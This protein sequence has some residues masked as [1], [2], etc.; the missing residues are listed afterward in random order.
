[1]WKSIVQDINSAI[2]RPFEPTEFLSRSVP[3]GKSINGGCINQA[4]LLSDGQQQYFVKLNRPEMAGMFAAEAAGLSEI[5]T[6]QTITVPT[7]ICAGVTDQHAYLALSYLDLAG[8]S[9]QAWEKLGAELAAL[10][11][12]DPGKRFGWYRNNTIG[13]TPQINDWQDN[14]VE[15]FAN[16]RL[17]YQFQ[18]AT[19]RGGRFASQQR[20][21]AKL[22][23]ILAH[24]PKP[25]I[26]HGDLWGGNAGFTGSGVPVI[27]DPAIYW[28]D[29]EVDL[30]MTELFGGF[31]GA[32]YAGYESVYPLTAGY[33]RRKV[34]YNLYHLLNHYNLFGGS[35][36]G[37]ANR[38]IEGILSD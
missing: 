11:R 32:F 5:A 38:A 31:P 13:S 9:A 20:L 25:S 2:N 6:T 37:Q 28:G 30:A 15:F 7:V 8:H 4:Y 14:W 16:Q 27:F 24:Q 1:M 36:E 23:E 3:G 21:L 34:V 12:F 19:T 10:H 26:V 33:E 17:G 22:P 35:Y 18:L 29:R